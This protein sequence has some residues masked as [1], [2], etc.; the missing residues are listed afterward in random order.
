VTRRSS[1]AVFEVIRGLWGR[2][3]G[4]PL[5]PLLPHDAASLEDFYDRLREFVER[6]PRTHEGSVAP[7]AC[8]D[9][10]IIAT[11]TGSVIE[12]GAVIHK[13]CRLI[14]GARSVVRAG[15]VL[16]DEVVVGSD[17]LV[18]AHCEVVRSVLLGPRTHVGHF[19]YIA[20]SIL[21]S[22]VNVSGNVMMA[23]TTVTRRASILLVHHGVKTDS[24]R[25]HLGALVGDGVRFGAST[26]ICPGC[27][28]LPHLAL[29]PGVVLHGTIDG[30]RRRR[31]I[32][33]F[34]RT[35]AA[36]AR[37]AFDPELAAAG[38]RR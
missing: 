21:G 7:H 1:A 3:P 38:E 11:G 15:A 16:R 29:P 28:V 13:S 12:S 22:D 37:S 32:T 2:P 20:D 9:G 14:L 34:S 27:I 23:N 24:R 25:S 33:Q 18:G 8:V 6:H 5:A 36:D 30:A 19:N 10:D 35:W 17:C 4:D 31:L 26:T